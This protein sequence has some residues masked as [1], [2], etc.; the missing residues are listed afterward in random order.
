M[1]LILPIDD[2]NPRLRLTHPWVNWSLV[3]LCVAV[4]VVQLVSPS[5][6]ARTL[7]NVAGV[8]PRMLVEAPLEGWHRNGFS[9]FL[10]PLTY[11]FLHG[12]FIHLAL[13]MLVLWVYG[14]NVEDAMGHVRYLTFYVICGIVAALSQVVINPSSLS[15]II[16][17]SGA[18]A[19]VMGAYFVLYPRARLLVPIFIFPVYLPAYLVLSFWMLFQF[20]AAVQTGS[21]G[22]GVAWW[23]HIGGFIAGALL[24]RLFRHRFHIQGIPHELPRGIE[25]VSYARDR[26]VKRANSRREEL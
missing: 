11:T 26:N 12:G 15:P 14:D 18:I 1:P 7:V 9:P 20:V 16:G 21:A 8:L 23:A 25:I 17:A 3:G 2:D 4:F 19:G 13:N 10:S 22:G 6:L 5:D 24:V